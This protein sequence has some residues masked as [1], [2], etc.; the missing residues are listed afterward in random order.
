MKNLTIDEFN[1]EHLNDI[2][3]MHSF[4]FFQDNPGMHQLL[5]IQ[6]IKLKNIDDF[7]KLGESKIVWYRDKKNN[8]RTEWDNPDARNIVLKDESS[9]RL[10]DQKDFK[11]MEMVNS[12]KTNGLTKKINIIVAHDE[13]LKENVI[14]DGVHRAVALF[15]LLLNHQS[16]LKEL[17]ESDFGIYLITL[18]SPNIGKYF[19]ADFLHIHRK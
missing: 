5:K 4:G 2:K 7:K 13:T 14:V 18:R 10:D 19:P 11:V 12:L 9:A 17:L 1:S 15:Y 6:K 16:N 3:V 8:L